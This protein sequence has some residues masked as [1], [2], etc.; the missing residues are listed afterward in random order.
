M[1]GRPILV[2]DGPTYS[3]P[4]GQAHGRPRLTQ[5]DLKLCQVMNQAGLFLYVNGLAQSSLTNLWAGL[6]RLEA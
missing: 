3:G 4:F 5:P 6:G 2:H 1:M